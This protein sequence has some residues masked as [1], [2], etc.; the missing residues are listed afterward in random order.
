MGPAEVIVALGIVVFLPLAMV[1]MILR[2]KTL[3]NRNRTGSGAGDSSLTMTELE[4]LMEDA[5]SRAV[6]PLN[7][8]LGA[9]ERKLDHMLSPGRE[10]GAAMRRLESPAASDSPE[11]AP[12]VGAAEK[13]VG[14][15]RSH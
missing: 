7:A 14:R 12:E 8:R 10:A 15:L 13:T 4:T 9:V 1:S 11:A 5:V 3:K 6:D 2:Y